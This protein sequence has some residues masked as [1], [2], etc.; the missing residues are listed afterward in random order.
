[1]QARVNG[2]ARRLITHPEI[3]CM[4]AATRIGRLSRLW[5]ASCK[6]LNHPLTWHPT[7]SLLRR[8]EAKRTRQMVPEEPELHAP[9]LDVAELIA[10]ITH[11]QRY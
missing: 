9:G 11:Q 7:K 8:P 6:P 3:R 2:R 10:V 4:V 1:M 5:L